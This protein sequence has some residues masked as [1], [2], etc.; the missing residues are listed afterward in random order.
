MSAPRVPGISGMARFSARQ[1]K[2]CRGRHDAV[3]PGRRL[4]GTHRS[5]RCGTHSRSSPE[6]PGFTKTG[7]SGFRCSSRSTWPTGEG[8]MARRSSLWRSCRRSRADRSRYRL[9]AG[10]GPCIRVGRPVQGDRAREARTGRGVRLQDPVLEQARPGHLRG[11]WR[12]GPLE[13]A[14]ASGGQVVGR[15][16]RPLPGN[17]AG[18]D[19]L[20]GRFVLEPE[21]G[22]GK[23]E[24]HQGCGAKQEPQPPGGPPARWRRRRP[25]RT[26]PPPPG[27]QS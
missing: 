2:W 22:T 13:G 11:P 24:R 16:G 7:R 20:P 12:R 15:V 19:V 25:R 14:L 1:S 4:M 17:R 10:S 6:S 3:P 5:I 27:R 9:P 8:L 21:A 23:D 18:E 26:V